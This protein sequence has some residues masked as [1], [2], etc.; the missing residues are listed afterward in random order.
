MK[1]SLE[2]LYTSFDSEAF[3]QDLD[4]VYKQLDEI[5]QWIS[6]NLSTTDNAVEKIEA[7]IN[8]LNDFSTRFTKVM[9]YV[10]LTSSVDVRNEEALQIM[11]Q[12]DEKYTELTKPMVI[13]QKWLASLNNID[14]LIDSSE[15][16]KTHAFFLQEMV[17]KSQ[18]LL[19]EE[20]EILISK[21]SNTGSSAWSKLQ[22]K[23]SST[24]LVEIDKEGK[25]EQL[26]LPIVR[27]MAY[28]KDADTR[29]K[30]YDAELKSYKKIEES[31][32]SALNGIKGEV[33]TV[34]KMRGFPSPL[35]ETIIDSRMNESTLR[36]MLEA[37][38]ETLPE[39]QKYYKKKGEL[40]GHK[41]GLPFYD[42]FA[43][44]GEVDMKFTYEEAKD[45]IVKHFRSFSDRL[46]DFTENAFEKQ[47]IDAEP[48]DGK[49]G[50]AFCSNLH[51]IKES[52]ILSNFTGSF[53]DVTTL[54]HELGHAYH[55]L[56]LSDNTIIN[57]HY[58]M[59]VA[60]TASIFCE[61]IIK[62]AALKDATEQ[63]AFSLLESSISDAG[64]VIVDIYSRFI[65]ES[66][67]FEKRKAHSLSVN[68]LKD[69]MLKSQEKAYGD[70]LDKNFL[71]PYM[72]INKPHYY[73]AGLN[74]YNFPYAFG[75]LFAKGV[76][77]KY[78]EQGDAFVKAYDQLLAATGTNDIKAV[79]QMVDIDITS[80]H[81]WK[82]S[83]DL[84][85]RDIHKFME[86]STAY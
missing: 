52:R 53:S 71:H 28:E 23:L 59:P 68:E 56:C 42:I 2:S 39:F 63:E 77:A 7:Y 8:M 60:E 49:R 6:S 74:F 76:Y 57:S 29:K 15:T 25:V 34:T 70:G 24:L 31:S 17:Q 16:A 45:Y 80:K 13:F 3:K 75:L 32:A 55:G 14:V 38:E 30:A 61:T 51:P 66:E 67:L 20:Q 40:L 11:D 69:I 21:M 62:E 47:W 50:G 33:L 83:L 73:Y 81:F 72:W 37:I 26:P 19:S 85:V 18:Y 35:E 12:L 41:N 48:R 46:A 54:A 43:P 22:E 4:L 65:F 10:S 9:S 36:A 1:W 58:P 84:V 86:L 27:N 79:A 64:Q 78:L 5:N 44:L 82:T